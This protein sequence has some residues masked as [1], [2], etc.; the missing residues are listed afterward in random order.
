MITA[1]EF[2][3][4]WEGRTVDEDDREFFER[5]LG[6]SR[7]GFLKLVEW[8]ANRPLDDGPDL[9]ETL[10]TESAMLLFVAE[11]D[12]F[13]TIP[14]DVVDQAAWL[15]ARAPVVGLLTQLLN[16]VRGKWNRGTDKPGDDWTL[17]GAAPAD[18]FQETL[19]GPLLTLIEQ[20]NETLDEMDQ[21]GDAV[22]EEAFAE[23]RNALIDPRNPVFQ[24]AGRAYGLAPN[25]L[26]GQAMRRLGSVPDPVAVAALLRKVGASPVSSDSGAIGEER[27]TEIGGE[28]VFLRK[29]EPFPYDEE[30]ADHPE[31]ERVTELVLRDG[32]SRLPVL[33]DMPDHRDR[34]VFADGR[35][36]GRDRDDRRTWERYL[37]HAMRRSGVLA[38][39]TFQ[40]DVESDGAEFV[41]SPGDANPLLFSFENELGER[42]LREGSATPRW[43]MLRI[44][45]DRN[46]FELR[47]HDRDDE[48]DLDDADRKMNEALDKRGVVLFAYKDDHV[49]MDFSDL[50]FD[51]HWHWNLYD[52]SGYSFWTD[53]F[54]AG[55]SRSVIAYLVDGDMVDMDT[56]R[57]MW[58]RSLLGP[59]IA[60]TTGS[61]PT[62]ASLEFDREEMFVNTAEHGA[63]RVAGEQGF[64]KAFNDGF[65]AKE[66]PLLRTSALGSG[67]A[68]APAGKWTFMEEFRSMDV[69]RNPSRESHAGVAHDAWTTLIGKL[70]GTAMPSAGTLSAFRD[71]GRSGDAWRNMVAFEGT[72]PERPAVSQTPFSLHSRPRHTSFFRTTGSRRR[73]EDG[74]KSD[75]LI[76][77][78]V[79]NNL[80]GFRPAQIH[81]TR[82]G[83]SLGPLAGLWSGTGP[84]AKAVVLR[85]DGVEFLHDREINSYTWTFD[86]STWR[87][88]VERIEMF[89]N[90]SGCF[91][92]M[93]SAGA[94]VLSPANGDFVMVLRRLDG[95]IGLAPSST[96]SASPY[97]F[98]DGAFRDFW[99]GRGWSY[100]KPAVYDIAFC[101]NSLLG[102][103]DSAWECSGPLEGGSFPG[104][105][106]SSEGLVIVNKRRDQKYSWQVNSGRARN[107]AW[108]RTHPDAIALMARF[109]HSGLDLIA[110]TMPNPSF[111][112]LGHSTSKLAW[113]DRS[114]AKWMMDPA[115]TDVELA[116][117]GTDSA[118]TGNVSLRGVP[119]MR[120]LANGTVTPAEDLGE[121]ALFSLGDEASRLAAKTSKT[122][123]DRAMLAWM[124][125]ELRPA[126][127]GDWLT[128]SAKLG[129][130]ASTRL[131]DLALEVWRTHAARIE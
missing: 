67:A 119:I 37:D 124:W 107:L 76:F 57:D 25:T 73:A 42:V 112:S 106:V 1:G 3:K 121:T 49:R 116:L 5:L 115:T 91:V 51:E 7:Q 30:D 101:V 75:S 16:D 131:G 109:R 125:E 2:E 100:D 13:S 4:W 79:S 98:G 87:S 128:E 35:A 48:D 40:V 19:E 72:A 26:I 65:S 94:D 105:S 64:R 9:L 28:L 122:N 92:R 34:L 46:L 84:A 78:Q 95:E 56:L 70:P 6:F 20:L 31:L 14:P 127:A 130:D 110:A 68:S 53:N 32:A 10:A 120:V 81:R 63:W 77:P 58:R 89:A 29:T 55:S 85:L 59:R 102:D 61:E 27:L 114:F 21:A 15:R 83:V 126:F 38:K 86:E 18:E 71:K 103:P 54:P 33:E 11:Q 82:H 12:R 97:G 50:T 17:R 99:R 24:N 60:A 36:Y 80:T 90:S 47:V 96:A 93:A 123:A 52:E 108:W 39:A 69:L 88:G 117:V 45:S 104:V 8:M 44:L 74:R 43:S 66:L 62:S 113:R 129:G 41:L 111:A 118:F 23:A 22:S